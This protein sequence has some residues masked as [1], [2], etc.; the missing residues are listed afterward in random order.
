MIRFGDDAPR[1][2]IGPGVTVVG[3]LRFERQVKLYLSDRATVGNVIGATAI[4][5]TGDDPPR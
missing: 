5:F 4:S 1:I 2:I 3:E